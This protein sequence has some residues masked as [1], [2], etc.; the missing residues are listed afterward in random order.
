MKTVFNVPAG[1]TNCLFYKVPSG[2]NLNFTKLLVSI[3]NTYLS[4]LNLQYY[5]VFRIMLIRFA[6]NFPNGILHKLMI[7]KID[8]PISLPTAAITHEIKTTLNG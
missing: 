5:D 6:D 7:E 2:F 3:D 4:P 1:G 8:I